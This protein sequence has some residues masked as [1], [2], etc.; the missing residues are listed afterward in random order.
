MSEGAGAGVPLPPAGRLVCDKG[1]PLEG[2]LGAPV[3][4][5]A[6]VPPRE[7]HQAGGLAPGERRDI[8]CLQGIPGARQ[9]RPQAVGPTADIQG[10]FLRES[11]A[12]V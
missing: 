12:T 4:V 7:C 5:S 10:T 2:L 3:G 1:V 8:H 6:A 11:L 9:D